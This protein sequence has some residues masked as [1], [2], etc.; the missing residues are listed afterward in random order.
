M[1]LRDLMSAMWIARLKDRPRPGSSTSGQRRFHGRDRPCRPTASA[2]ARSPGAA[3]GPEKRNPDVVREL[4]ST[5]PFREIRARADIESARTE[6]RLGNVAQCERLLVAA[7]QRVKQVEETAGEPGGKSSAPVPDAQ[8]HPGAE[9]SLSPVHAVVLTLRGQCE[10]L[11][12]S[13]GE[14]DELLLM[15]SRY[16]RARPLTC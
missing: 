14:G 10:R 4:A 12:Q 11:R 6:L 2:W 8:P 13:P 3:H 15:L 16:S 5:G 1:Q 9:L 7:V